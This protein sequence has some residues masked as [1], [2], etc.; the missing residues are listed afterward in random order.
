MIILGT[1]DGETLFECDIRPPFDP[2]AWQNLAKAVD[3]PYLVTTHEVR[4]KYVELLAR[5]DRHAVRDHEG[6]AQI[7]WQ[8]IPVH[9]SPLCEPGRV[10]FINAKAFGYK[11]IKGP[12]VLDD[13]DQVADSVRA[14]L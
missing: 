12:L 14:E 2:R 4:N 6:F 8:G 1:L 9:T 11:D 10:Y 7:L 13:L 3:H 5:N